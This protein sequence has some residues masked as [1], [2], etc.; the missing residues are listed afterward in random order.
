MVTLNGTNSFKGNLQSFKGNCYNGHSFWFLSTTHVYQLQSG[1]WLSTVVWWLLDREEAFSLLS[2]HFL[3]EINENLVMP[4]WTFHS[5]DMTSDFWPVVVLFQQ[6]C[7]KA[8]MWTLIWKKFCFSLTPVSV[9]RETRYTLQLQGIRFSE[10]L[11][12]CWRQI[13]LHWL[14]LNIQG[15]CNLEGG[16]Y[17]VISR[18]KMC[19]SAIGAQSSP[20]TSQKMEKLRITQSQREGQQLKQE[21][22]YISFS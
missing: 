14:Q 4:Y 17:A 7:G 22:W 13:W 9:G 3:V 18:L 20:F 10:E 6:N 15:N 12:L 5:P 21:V 16:I 8:V 19:P 1:C 11:V 2:G